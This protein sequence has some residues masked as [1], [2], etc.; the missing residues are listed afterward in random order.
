MERINMQSDDHLKLKAIVSAILATK[1]V[2][3]EGS[4]PKYI[5][6]RYQQV[7][8]ALDDAGGVFGTDLLEP[9]T[10]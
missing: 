6:K 3:D 7:L 5:V 9:E 8:Q 2:T 10:P 1:T 4:S